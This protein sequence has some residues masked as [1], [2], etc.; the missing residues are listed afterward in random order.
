MHGFEP[1]LDSSAPD[2]DIE[3][4]LNDFAAKIE[5]YAQVCAQYSAGSLSLSDI[6]RELGEAATDAEVFFGE[7]S[8]RMNMEQLQ[9]YALLQ[10]RLD[11]LTG[12]VFESEIASNQAT[13]LAA[14][15]HGDYFIVNLTYNAIKSSLHMIYVKQKIKTQQEQR[16]A[17]TQQDLEIAQTFIKVLKALESVLRPESGQ[18]EWPKIEKALSIYRDYFQNAPPVPLKQASD[19]RLFGLFA[20]HAQALQQAQTPG[21]QMHLA[22]CRTILAGLATTPEQQALLAGWESLLS[23]S[24]DGANRPFPKATVAQPMNAALETQL[25][26]QLEQVARALQVESE[27]QLSFMGLEAQLQQL[28]AQLYAAGGADAGTAHRVFILFEGYFDFLC[29]VNFTQDP[30]SAAAHVVRC[31]ES[32]ASLAQTPYQAQML[33]TWRATPNTVNILAQAPRPG[34]G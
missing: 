27:A 11:S 9:R 28:S 6:T 2:Q 34:E 5:N 23:S 8:H 21:W 26:H 14:I 30:A 3:A 19:R 16:L 10:N 31:C 32:L 13:I 29:N 12:Q 25:A 15:E 7:Q 22:S 17:E 33:D 24:T 20:E 4:Q 1:M 18:L